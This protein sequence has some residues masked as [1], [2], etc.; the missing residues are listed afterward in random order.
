MPKNGDA[1]KTHL[2]GALA[3]EGVAHSGGDHAG[4]FHH[5]LGLGAGLA[6]E[7]LPGAAG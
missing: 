4:L 7:G 5:R 2:T 6:A 1:S 3:C